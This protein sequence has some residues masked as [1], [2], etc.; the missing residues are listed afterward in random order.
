MTIHLGGAVGWRAAAVVVG[1]A[2]ALA[3]GSSASAAPLLKDKVATTPTAAR[4]R[5]LDLGTLGGESSIATAMNDRGAVVG[6][7]QAADGT[8]HGFLWRSGAML[9]L[10]LF[11]PRDINNHGQIVG[12]RDDG[13][14]AYRWVRG[15]FTQL[16]S[17]SYP[18]AVND[19][20]DVVGSMNAGN[21]QDVPVRWRRGN[22]RAVPL[23]S[24][25]DINNRSQIAGGEALPTGGFHASVWH[26]G[27]LTDLGAAAFDRSNTYG[28]ND[29]GWI[30]G[31]TY[32]ADQ[33]ERGALW[34]QGK[35]TDLGTLGGHL[36]RAV[37]IN[38]RGAIL[39][40]SQVADGNLHPALWKRG[41][42]TDLTA[43]GVSA[44]GDVVD[45]N[46]RGE[47]V[48]SIRPEFGIAR[49]ILYRPKR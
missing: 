5:A 45:L 13:S 15:T 3:G 25:S 48:A 14:G 17:M 4:Y 43:A 16:G 9:D 33:F 1:V 18:I 12:T 19:R 40:T 42:L 44:D 21:G 26:R 29:K 34:R 23:D 10:G 24:V 49:A 38:D 31:W 41:V 46:N 7:A 37:A 22:V 30:I 6:R 36:T 47:I 35:R 28:I 39:A 8:W 11:S 2:L 27:R 20:G 32:S